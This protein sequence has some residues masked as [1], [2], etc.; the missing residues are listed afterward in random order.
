M[1]T[2]H[3]FE[4]NIP[5]LIQRLGMNLYND[6]FVCLRE[7]VQNASDACLIAEGTLGLGRGRIDIEISQHERTVTI[8]D[9]GIGMTEEELHKYLSTIAASRKAAIRRELTD[10]FDGSS[11]IAGR[12]GIGF[13]AVFIVSDDVQ[14][15]TRHQGD[16]GN[17]YAW[18]SRG[19][20]NYTV[21]ASQV[22][23]P[24]GTSI[25]VSVRE[26]AIELLQADK[27]VR[28]LKHHCPFIRTPYFINKSALSVN[29]DLPP[30]YSGATDDAGRT[31]ML[32]NFSC[33][34]VI[35]LPIHFDGPWQLGQVELGSRYSRKRAE[36]GRAIS[37]LRIDGYFCIPNKSVQYNSERC[38]IYTSGLFVGS[39]HDSLPDWANFVA[40]GA[41]C[42][43]LDLTLGRDNVMENPTW[44]AA[45]EILKIELTKSI[46][47]SLKDKRPKTR[48]AWTSVFQ[49]HREQ[50]LRAGV[51][52]HRGNFGEPADDRS[53]PFFAA[54]KDLIPFRI[55]GDWLSID[56]II[57][58]NR[59]MKRD[60]K[61]FVFYQSRGHRSHESAGVQEKILFEEAGLHSIPLS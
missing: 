16:A 48:R 47:N 35:E 24:K 9:T 32:E 4:T 55:G 12:F 59:C 20:G 15:K 52:E 29:H 54:V 51:D 2:T 38:R 37:R 45:Q 17:G 11:G 60:G 56:E 57:Q 22:K 8:T 30:W 14:V 18:R 36:K 31:Y 1:K 27:L 23:L 44:W 49:I 42:P 25:R 28:T 10:K 58:Q 40:G 3:Q 43:D 50:M 46:V 61:T 53:A 39:V 21:E 5:Q 33:D 6:K 26:D 41:E 19:D 34:P 13:L 7:L